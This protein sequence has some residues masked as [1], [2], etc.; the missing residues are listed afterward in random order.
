MFMREVRGKSVLGEAGTAWIKEVGAED[1]A[2]LGSP[3]LW[4]CLVVRA[5]VCVMACVHMCDCVSTCVCECTFVPVCLSALL[6]MCVPLC[7]CVCACEVVGPVSP[8]GRD[9]GSRADLQAPIH[10]SCPTLF[11][12]EKRKFLPPTSRNNPKFEELQ[13]V[14]QP[15]LTIFLWRSL[16]TFLGWGPWATPSPTS[17]W[18]VATPQAPGRPVEWLQKGSCLSTNGVPFCA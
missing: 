14:R 3:G 5:C 10:V 17:S 12:G 9:A 15:S 4:G 2:C 7:V 18:W 11:P 1:E 16:P 6:H 13:K 8:L